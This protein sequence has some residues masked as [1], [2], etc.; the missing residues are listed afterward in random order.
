M[1]ALV[2]DYP[3][4]QKLK[5]LDVESLFDVVVA[6]GEANGPP[7]LKPW[8]DGLLRAAA[9]LN[10]QPQ[11]CLVVG[12][13]PD[14]DGLAAYRAGMDYAPPALRLLTEGSLAGRASAL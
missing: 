14:L 11:H 13:R 10:V 8:P 9:V 1:T 3:A 6:N 7:R 4:R 12:D 5:A 2:S